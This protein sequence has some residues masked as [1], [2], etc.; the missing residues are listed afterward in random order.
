LAD[1][2]QVTKVTVLQ[3]SLLATT[4]TSQQRHRRFVSFSCQKRKVPAHLSPF[5]RA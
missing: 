3:D 1:R 5:H 2:W 4:G